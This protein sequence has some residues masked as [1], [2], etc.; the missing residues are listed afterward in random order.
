MHY[1]GKQL[2]DVAFYSYYSSYLSPPISTFY[3]IHNDT[4]STFVNSVVCKIMSCHF[5]SAF[6]LKQGICCVFLGFCKLE[7]TL[8]LLKHVWSAFS[9]E[10]ISPRVLW[11][12][13]ETLL[14]NLVLC[15]E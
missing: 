5:V 3:V 2:L 6:K 9:P 11:K 8:L 4:I 1:F 14:L 13:E 10:L 12:V 7:M 15:G